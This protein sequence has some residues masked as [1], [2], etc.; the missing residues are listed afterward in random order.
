MELLL[1]IVEL[2]VADLI[3]GGDNAVVISMATKNL[4]QDMKL[5]ASMYG[6]LFAIILR[7]IFILIILIF[8][9]QHI[10]LLNILAGC[11]LIK[12][13]F[14]LISPEEEE[15]NVSDSKSLIKAIKSIVIAD[16]VMSF[17]NAI[18][19]ASIVA[20]TTFSI[21]LQVILIICA[22]LVS[23]PIIIFGASILSKVIEKYSFVVYFFGILLIHIAVELI[24]KDTLFVK[25]DIDA[26]STIHGLQV[27]AIALAIFAVVWF[28]ASKREGE[29]VEA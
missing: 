20:A 10:I 4:P 11:L 22:L 13:A 7:V 2:I 19:I 24:I 25:Y 5:K 18:V 28:G 29:T 14:D 12:V 15:V 26:I 6:A 8:G 9:E 1:V 16:A 23:F 17:D 27:W 21:Q 3:L